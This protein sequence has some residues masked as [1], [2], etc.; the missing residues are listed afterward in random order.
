MPSHHL[1]LVVV[2]VKSHRV[3][4]NPNKA[5]LVN[6]HGEDN[7]DVIGQGDELAFHDKLLANRT[8]TLVLFGLHGFPSLYYEEY[9]LRLVSLTIGF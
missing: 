8:S 6:G 2:L 1:L 9:S 5:T 7:K 4:V 3:W